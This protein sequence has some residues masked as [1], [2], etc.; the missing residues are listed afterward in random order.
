MTDDFAEG[1]SEWIENL[2]T[3]IR[4]QEGCYEKVRGSTDPTDQAKCKGLVDEIAEM[5]RLL[6]KAKK[7][8]GWKA[9]HKINNAVLVHARATEAQWSAIDEIPDSTIH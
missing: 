5:K 6:K 3:L 9:L 1:K 8:R 2:K 7:A 4:G